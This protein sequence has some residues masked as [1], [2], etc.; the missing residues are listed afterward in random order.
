MGMDVRVVMLNLEDAM[1]ESQRLGSA[2]SARSWQSPYGADRIEPA[3][4][5]DTGQHFGFPRSTVVTG[6]PGR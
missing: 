6:V 1:R 2:E 4:A 5:P 3:A